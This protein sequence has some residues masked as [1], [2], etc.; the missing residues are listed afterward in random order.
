MARLQVRHLQFDADV[1]VFDKDGTLIDFH[2]LWGKRARVSVESLVEY[3]SGDDNIRNALHAGLGYD[4]KTHRTVV[5]GPVA[6]I[7][8]S[9]LLVVA[10]MVLY[11]A[12]FEWEHAE[13]AV[14]ASFKRVLKRPP[15]TDEVM[16]LGK[17]RPTIE[18]LFAN[19]VHIAVATTDDRDL[20]EL[21]LR[22]LQID[23]HV[24]LVKCGD[25]D[26]PLK[27]SPEVIHGI[28]QH[29]GT[30]ND[31]IVMVGDIPS[32]LTMARHANCACAIGV[33]NGA[34]DNNVLSAV[35]D[36]VV[37]SIDEIEVI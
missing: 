21:A 12:G 7:A 5:G 2:A 4:S 30:T 3:I 31:R 13:N 6:T 26:G 24:S 18:H 25:D 28:A 10:T 11:Q 32:D 27:P 1:I 22:H 34:G 29:Y 19:D 8:I 37:D 36:A 14:N 16:P 33:V 23:Q 15:A 17:V 20:T 35:A 9:K